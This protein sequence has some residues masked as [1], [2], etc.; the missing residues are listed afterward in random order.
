VTLVTLADGTERDIDLDIDAICAYEEEHPDW[1][2]LDLF[3]R[4]EKMRFTDLNLM[5]MLLGF[6]DYKDALEQGVDITT[7]GDIVQN[8]KLMGFTGSPAQGE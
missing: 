3:Q 1:S 7:M 5:S 2:I 4:M 8:S 6:R